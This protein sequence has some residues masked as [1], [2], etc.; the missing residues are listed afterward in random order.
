MLLQLCDVRQRYGSLS[1]NT[2]TSLSIPI[3]IYRRICSTVVFGFFWSNTLC[4]KLLSCYSRNG[5]TT[6]HYKRKTD[7]NA[8]L[9]KKVLP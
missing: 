1:V 8:F 4:A 3:A 2:V 6:V 7:Y 5:Q 9:L